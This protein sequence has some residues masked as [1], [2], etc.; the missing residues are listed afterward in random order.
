[1]HIVTK[2][3]FRGSLGLPEGALRDFHDRAVRLGAPIAKSAEV[4]ASLVRLT[5]I[6]DTSPRR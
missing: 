3:E 2:V 6:A 1:V 5:R 4:A